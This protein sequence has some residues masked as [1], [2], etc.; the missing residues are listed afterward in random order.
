M[1][2]VRYPIPM[3]TVPARMNTHQARE[4]I[5]TLRSDIRRHDLL[6]YGEDRPEISD[7]VYDQLFAELKKL[8]SE[9]P[10]LV[11]SDSPTQRVAG[12]P[13]DKF[14]T[15]AHEAPMLSLE[16]DQG[17]LSERPL[18]VMEIWAKMLPQTSG[19][20]VRCHSDFTMLSSRFRS[21]WRYAE[22]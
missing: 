9:H 16:S 3:K 1:D 4:R 8:E 12:V 20:F 18:A 22:R 6:Y 19:P 2:R 11:T 17:S 10:E 7:D 5:E 14:E 15:V 21:V 13:L